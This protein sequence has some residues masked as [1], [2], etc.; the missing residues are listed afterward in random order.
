ML[1]RTQWGI[2]TQAWGFQVDFL[3]EVPSHQGT[4]ELRSPSHVALIKNAWMAEGYPR[5]TDTGAEGRSR[6]GEARKK[7]GSNSTNPWEGLLL[8]RYQSTRESSL[9]LINADRQ[10]R[11]VARAQVSGNLI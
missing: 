9:A 10:E 7:K 4:Q 3:K 1:S 6:Q 11:E 8:C 2:L 5:N